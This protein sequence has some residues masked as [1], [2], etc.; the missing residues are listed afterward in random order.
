[1]G[2]SSLHALGVRITF[3][4]L[5]FLM[6]FL[7]KATVA[8]KV[9]FKRVNWAHQNIELKGS[10]LEQPDNAIF[11]GVCLLFKVSVETLSSM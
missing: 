11:Y 5:D 4:S 9:S 3:Y 8:T 10:P 6:G 2:K 7:R 1:M